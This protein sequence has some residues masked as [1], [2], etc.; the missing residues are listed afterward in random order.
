[1]SS[2]HHQAMGHVYHQL[3]ERMLGHFTQ[4]QRAAL[5][6]LIQRLT[7][8]AGG[9]GALG[10]YTI[11]LACGGGKDSLQ[12]LAFL[13][14][15]QLSIS[16]RSPVTF[17][18]R[19]ATCRQ[20]GLTSAAFANVQ[21]ACSALFLRDDPRIELLMVDEHQVSALAEQLPSSEAA[22]A[23]CRINMLMSGH[24]TAGDERITFGNGCYLTL[25]DFYQ[26]A[27]AHGEGVQA[28]AIAGPP[29]ELRHYL[30]WGLRAAYQANDQ[31]PLI[32]DLL[33]ALEHLGETY[34]RQLHGG[35]PHSHE[36]TPGPQAGASLPAL[37]AFRLI[38]LHS[39]LDG[40]S[41]DHWPLLTDFLGFEFL[42]QGAGFNEL[43]CVSPLLLAHLRGLRAQWL[44]GQS[45]RRGVQ[46][47]LRLGVPLMRRKGTPEKLVRQTLASWHGQAALD[48]RRADAIDLR[49]LT[50][51]VGEAQLV[52]LLF[53]PFVEHGTGLRAYL[54]QCHPPML[55]QLAALHGALQGLPST[56]AVRRWLKDTSGLSAVALQRLY[57]LRRVD[58]SGDR[59]LMATLHASD[60]RRS[61]D[62]SLAPLTGHAV[63]SLMA[64]AQ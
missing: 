55:P 13:R 36:G 15:A 39:L 49:G 54:Q 42:G 1:M 19:I 10:Q 22:R 45:Y 61:H 16:Q 37:P 29:R 11:L 27:L 34:Y 47:F 44:Q 7:V 31:R 60:P 58:L 14:A 18:L 32:G 56:P 59:S 38:D 9:C 5:Q 63:R 3:L 23:T 41:L 12:T 43:D 40:D 30:A 53:S 50:I 17:R 24:L 46:D 35:T 20:A 26:R 51:G 33:D 57:R 62:Q 25:V 52:C 21:R 6:L 64:G 2:I 48:Q 28:V 8:A 4:A